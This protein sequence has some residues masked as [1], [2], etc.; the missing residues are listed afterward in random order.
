M[1]E[2]EQKLFG[3]TR[4]RCSFKLICCVAILGVT[5]CKAQ[6]L[7]TMQDRKINVLSGPDGLG[8]VYGH[9]KIL[10]G[11]L[12]ASQDIASALKIEGM[13]IRAIGDNCAEAGGLTLVF[14]ASVEKRLT[15]N[16]KEFTVQ[17][18]KNDLK[19]VTLI[20]EKSPCRVVYDYTIKCG[21]ITRIT[22][23]FADGYKS[24]FKK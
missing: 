11:S 2:N 6:P 4:T 22:F 19:H 3:D 21:Q 9:E 8:F 16:G 13:H 10:M 7:A 12:P 20:C 23:N 17:T 5:A 18:E 1:V 14:P 24:T 15:C